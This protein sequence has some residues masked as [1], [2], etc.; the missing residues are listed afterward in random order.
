MN[1]KDYK[2]KWENSLIKNI[3]FV[4]LTLFFVS[5]SKKAI[6]EI[7]YKQNQNYPNWYINPILNSNTT[8]YGVGEGRNID[9]ATKSALENLSSRLLVTI[10]SSTSISSKSYRDFR[11]YTTSTVTQEINSQ[12]QIL[13]FKNYLI[14]ETKI[15]NRKIVVQVSVKKE[16][17]KNSLKD[18]LN[19]IYKEY[20]FI[21]HQ[22]Y[23]N[24]KQYIK[25]DEILLKLYK[26]SKKA[27]IAESL[28]YNT[29]FIQKIDTIKQ[30]LENLK[31]KISFYIN[32][33]TN[34]K[35]YEDIF[36]ESLTK[37]GF[38]VSNYKNNSYI[39]DLKSNI[40]KK[41]PKGF[42]IIEDILSVTLINSK[43]SF[44]KTENLELKGASS[45]DFQSAKLNLVQKLKKEQEHYNILPF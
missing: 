36:K 29:D 43:N 16:D 25:K 5:C 31:N 27:Q 30:E 3:F 23:D 42:F 13:D 12:T 8:L 41:S 22:K 4:F 6:N 1:K 44:I 18:E 45:V 10:D 33:D 7:A 9:E 2:I 14:D 19:Q 20:D 28:G 26:N 40:S 37:R 15:I 32:C 11:E 34:S 35:I 21:N 24:L 39:L 38:K 17:L